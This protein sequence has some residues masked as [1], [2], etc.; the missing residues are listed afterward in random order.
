MR[1]A[2]E[3]EPDDKFEG[4]D[5]CAPDAFFR[6]F[7]DVRW[8][9]VMMEKAG[10]DAPEGMEEHGRGMYCQRDV[11]NALNAESNRMRVSDSDEP[12]RNERDRPSQKIV[13]TT[14]VP[15]WNAGRARKET[16]MTVRNAILK[17]K[18]VV[19]RQRS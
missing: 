4:L 16:G 12:K 10:T 14:S 5:V 2:D 9:L 15:M 11:E 8:L 17:F 1:T 18:R 19:S 7:W 13:R 6:V 3:Q